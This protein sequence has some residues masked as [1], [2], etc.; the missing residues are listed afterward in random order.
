MPTL[1]ENGLWLLK[2]LVSLLADVDP[3]NPKT[4]ITYS[5]VHD[6]LCLRRIPGVTSNWQEPAVS[7]AKLSLGDWTRDEGTPGITGLIIDASTGMPG[8]GFFKLFRIR[9]DD[10]GW[11]RQEVARCK[12]Y[13]WSIFVPSLRTTDPI[14]GEEGKRLYKQAQEAER[15][16]K[17]RCAALAMNKKQHDGMYGCEACDLRMIRA[18]SSTCIT[19]C[20]SVLITE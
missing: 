9:D 7:R 8:P 16:P 12:S 18:R 1:D 20:R 13:D 11:L 5:Q 2:L 14:S 4:F 19:R 6:R 10:Y 3:N 17:L 15:D